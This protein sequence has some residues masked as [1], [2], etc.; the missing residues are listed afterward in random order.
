MPHA[1]GMKASAD[2]LCPGAIIPQNVQDT[3]HIEALL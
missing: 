3:M 2:S 1:D